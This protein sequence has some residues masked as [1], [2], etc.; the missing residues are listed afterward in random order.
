MK[1]LIL[2]YKNQLEALED[3]ILIGEIPDGATRFS[4]EADKLLLKTLD[5]DCE[6]SLFSVRSKQLENILSVHNT[7]MQWALCDNKS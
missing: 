2:H 6:S 3:G 7:L 1:N 4:A 5:F